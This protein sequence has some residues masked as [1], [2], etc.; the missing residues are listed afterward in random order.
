MQYLIAFDLAPEAAA[1]W[2]VALQRRMIAVQ[3]QKVQ[4]KAQADMCLQ[5]EDSFLA[6]DVDGR[7]A[8]RWTP[9]W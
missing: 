3:V 9:A 6:M 5:A 4:R 2:A 8:P 7:V 1:A